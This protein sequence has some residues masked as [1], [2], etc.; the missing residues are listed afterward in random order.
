VQRGKNHTKSR[1]RAKV[2]HS[3]GVIKRVFGYPKARYR[4]LA[5]NRQRLWLSCGLANLV[6]SA[7][8]CGAPNRRSVSG[9]N[10]PI[11]TLRLPKTLPQMRSVLVLSH[12]LSPTP[13][14]AVNASACSEG[15]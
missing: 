10:R 13:L 4:G 6:S 3:I 8:G 12:P 2:E 7:G 11:Q 1:V 15:P 9:V 14:A 5:K